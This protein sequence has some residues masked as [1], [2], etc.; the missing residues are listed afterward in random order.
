MGHEKIGGMVVFLITGCP[1]S[2]TG[3]ALEV[4]RSVGYRMGEED[5][6]DKKRLDG[7]VSWKHIAL[8]LEKFDSIFH[9][10]REPLWVISSMT[11][12]A[13]VNYKFMER[14]VGRIIYIKINFI[15]VC[16][17]G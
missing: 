7:V 15:G 5:Y 9:Q 6:K 13:E 10:V 4:L 17:S 16:G 12:M 2:G 8:M 11:T 1:R 3:Y 14:Y